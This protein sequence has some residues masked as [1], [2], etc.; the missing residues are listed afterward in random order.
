[1]IQPI[2]TV[3]DASLAGDSRA[4]ERDVFGT[5]DAGEI[6]AAVERFCRAQLGCGAAG[7]LFY[8]SSVGCVLGLEL[9]DGRRA[10]LKVHQPDKS[11]ARLAGCQAVQAGLYARGFPCPEPL[12]GPRPLGRGLAVVERYLE[13]GERRD[14]RDPA[15]RYEIAARLH[16]LIALARS[17]R[18]GTDLGGSWFGSLPP[19]Q[20]WPRPHNPRI[21]L[22]ATARGAEWI[23]ELARLARAVPLTGERVLGHFD[24]R[25][26]H[27]RFEA[28][29]ISTVY[30]WDSL[31]FEREPIA[32]GCAAAAFSTD[33]T[34]PELP[35]AP[36]PD[37]IH[38]FVA[39]Y[40]QARGRAF[41]PSERRTAYAACVYLIAYVARCQHADRAQGTSAREPAFIELLAAAG[42]TLLS[43][44]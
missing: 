23:D 36:S 28:G 38:S 41:E 17:A 37:E 16:E 4:V 10:V 7:A 39:S 21:D 32:A 14:A 22:A 6:D 24:W 35:L 33:W 29:R 11:A 26:E 15:I 2:A 43:S 3:I 5:T 12:L 31:H 25:V 1:L 30:D 27:F 20:L 34:R 18:L 13:R 42:S 9:A 40:E 19:E 8:E 44:S